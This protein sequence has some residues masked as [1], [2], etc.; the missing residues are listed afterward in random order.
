VLWTSPSPRAS[1]EERTSPRVPNATPRAPSPTARRCPIGRQRRRPRWL[2]QGASHAAVA[3]EGARRASGTS[4]NPSASGFGDRS[5]VIAL[6]ARAPRASPR[7][8][9]EQRPHPERRVPHTRTNTAHSI[10][11]LRAGGRFRASTPRE[12]MDRLARSDA[13]PS[14][15]PR[16]GGR[17]RD[18][19]TPKGS[20]S[21][22][23]PGPSA[24]PA[25]ARARPRGRER[26]PACTL[27]SCLALPLGTRFLCD[28]HGPFCED[29]RLGQSLGESAPKAEPIWR[30]QGRRQLRKGLA[31]SAPRCPR[32]LSR[33]PSSSRS[34]RAR[35]G[36]GSSQRRYPPEPAT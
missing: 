25:L 23:N 21:K 17:R 22:P 2:S 32:R 36:A 28:F 4:A 1:H 13:P 19:A 18:G 33:S 6:A 16:R 8:R 5:S 26:E 34:R 29:G 27:R 35:P 12:V 14:S 20:C 24:A 31:D 15:P 7:S 9:L 10:R 3:F 30:D 11:R